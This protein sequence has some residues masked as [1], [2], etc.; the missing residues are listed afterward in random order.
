MASIQKATR[1]IPTQ[2]NESVTEEIS[3]VRVPM[4][5]GYRVFDVPCNK[6]KQLIPEKL[7]ELKIEYEWTNENEG[8]LTVGPVVEDTESGNIYLRVRQTYFF[9]VVCRDEAI[10]S[11]TGEAALDGLNDDEEWMAITDVS[12]IEKYAMK[13]LQS[14]EL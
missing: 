3:K 8:L 14:L 6:V 2:T 12:I 1:A 10:T 5:V 9:T 13:F 11:I 7:E 4:G